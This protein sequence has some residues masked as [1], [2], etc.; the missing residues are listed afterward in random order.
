MSQITWTSRRRTDRQSTTMTHRPIRLWLL[1]RGGDGLPA[2]GPRGDV[3]IA[4]IFAVRG[5]LVV[6]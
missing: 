1:L 4:P 2:A 3:R 5:Y 6:V